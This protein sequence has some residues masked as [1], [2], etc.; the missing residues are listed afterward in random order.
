MS[1]EIDG[2]IA[3][4]NGRLKSNNVGVRIERSHNRLC[5]R[6][7][8]PPKPTSGLDKPCQQRI[9]LSCRANPSGLKLAEA[10]ARKVSALL[11]CKQFSWEPYLKTGNDKELV[12]ASEWVEKFKEEYF[13]RRT[14]SPKTETTWD[15]DYMAVFKRLP[16]DCE[17]SAAVLRELVLTTE[18]DTRGRKRYCIALGALAKFAA[19][20]FSPSSLA[21]N[22][23]PRKVVP[24]DL[25]TDEEI[26]MWHSKI[27][28]KA[29]QWAYGM[30]ATY[31]LRPH[32]LFHL[33]FDDMPILT[34][35][36]GKTG[37]RR[38]WACY[39][40]WVDELGLAEV[41]LPLATSKNNSGLGERVSQYFRRSGLPFTPY[42]LRHCWAIR[43]LEFGLDISLAAQQMGHSVQVHSQTY[44]RWISD[45]HHQRAYDLLMNRP[46]RP[47]AP[48]FDV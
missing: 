40:E 17:M 36:D 46:D 1:A 22:Y 35:L 28:H 16:D 48:R 47:K 11:D 45:R 37:S 10:E 9:Y 32:E 15:K 14:K 6:S 31:G 34:V 43:T 7:T 44:H 2:K 29:W 12:F 21:G 20:D 41:N 18:P 4:A 27:K 8:L 26:A 39:P 23:S 5:L 42:C 19:I 25:P 30:L 24:R 33:N 13:N 38:I 3:Q